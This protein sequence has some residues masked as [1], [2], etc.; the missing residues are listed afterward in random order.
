MIAIGANELGRLPL[1]QQ[2]ALKDLLEKSK[3]EGELSAFVSADDGTLYLNDLSPVAAKI[4][5]KGKVKKFVEW[6]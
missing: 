5:S 6:L 3:M 2:K 1:R 4:S